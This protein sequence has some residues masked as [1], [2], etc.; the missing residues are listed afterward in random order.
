M[1]VDPDAEIP[2]GYSKGIMPTNFGQTLSKT[3]IKDLVDFLVAA[4]H[5]K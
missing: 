1:I 4:T 5:T 2:K 3:Q